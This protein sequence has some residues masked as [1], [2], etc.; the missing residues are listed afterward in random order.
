[1]I[2]VVTDRELI[3]GSCASGQAPG[4]EPKTLWHL[5][6]YTVSR[7]GWFAPT[8]L[9]LGAA[10]RYTPGFVALHLPPQRRLLTG[11]YTA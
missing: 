9:P 8:Q 7:A 6:T 3:N 5:N 4:D 2:A 11:F 10:E 1:M